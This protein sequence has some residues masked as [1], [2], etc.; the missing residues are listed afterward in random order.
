[1]FLKADKKCCTESY[2]NYD[3]I[4]INCNWVSNRW[5][6]SVN[7]YTNK[8]AA[9]IYTRRE[10]TK[11]QNTQNRKQNIKNRKRVKQNIIKSKRHKAKYK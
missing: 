2:A 3:V 8:E 6:W 4:F 5:Q 11:T 10:N 1:M 7:L 9:A